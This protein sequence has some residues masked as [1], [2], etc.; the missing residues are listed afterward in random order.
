M[1]FLCDHPTNFKRAVALIRSDLRSIYLAAFQSALWN[2]WLS[3]IIESKFGDSVS[4][5]SS[6]IGQLALPVITDGDSHNAKW[7]SDLA[8]PI[9]TPRQHNGPEKW[10]GL[11]EAVLHP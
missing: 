9:P 8:L 4:H 6:V 2:Q 5:F 3:K 7:L 10:F 1:T 11:L